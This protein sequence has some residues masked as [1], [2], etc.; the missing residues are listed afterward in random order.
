MS[1]QRVNPFADIE[2]APRFDTKPRTPHPVV[3]EDIERLAQD[4]NFPSR[5][6]AR[7][8]EPAPAPAHR[9]RRVYKTGRNQQLNFKA[10]AET[11][12]RFYHMADKKQVPLCELLEQALDALEQK[13]AGRNPSQITS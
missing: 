3:P 5:Q 4:N 11:I 1:A 12:D 9:K 8:I 10:T 13:D 7:T 2:G 6:A